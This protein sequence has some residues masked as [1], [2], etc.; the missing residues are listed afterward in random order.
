MWHTYRNLEIKTIDSALERFMNL[1]KLKVWM[2]GRAFG[3][4]VLLLASTWPRARVVLYAQVRK[5]KMTLY[6]QSKKV[7]VPRCS[8]SF[9]GVWGSAGGTPNGLGRF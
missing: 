7:M 1:T 8:L 3:C 9:V 2:N 5:A 6:A 4:S